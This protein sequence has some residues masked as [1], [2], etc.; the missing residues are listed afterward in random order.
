M[1]FK[2]LIGIIS[3]DNTHNKALSCLNT[4]LSEVP[5]PHEYFFASSFNQSDFSEKFINCQPKEGEHRLRLPEKTFKML[6]KALEYDWDFFYKC[7]DDTYLV[8]DRLFKYLKNFNPS[9]DLYIGHKI[10]NPFPYAQGGSGYILSRSSLSKCLSVLGKIYANPVETK[11]CE[12]Y[13]VGKCFNELKVP[14]VHAP[15]FHCPNPKLAKTNQDCC[16]DG[17]IKRNSICSHYVSPENQTRIYNKLKTI[18]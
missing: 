6:T 15:E 12:D 4:W 11:K 1:S 3:C 16:F 14:L 13:A 17:I 8:F 18:S 7:D 2:I 9:D 10:Y 5:A